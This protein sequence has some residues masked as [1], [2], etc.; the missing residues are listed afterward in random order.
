MHTLNTRKN[1]ERLP[2]LALY[3]WHRLKVKTL[4]AINE[5]SDRKSIAAEDRMIERAKRYDSERRGFAERGA[6]RWQG[7]SS[8]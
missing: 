1:L 8:K 3:W 4:H 2:V 6:H 7:G 5:W